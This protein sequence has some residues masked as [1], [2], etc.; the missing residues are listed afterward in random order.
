M[1]SV[2]FS[3]LFKLIQHEVYLQ[4]SSRLFLILFPLSF[5]VGALLLK[6]QP[7][8][9]DLMVDSPYAL[10]KLLILFSITLP[11][12]VTLLSINASTRDHQY[13][14]VEL[15][16]TSSITPSHLVLSRWLGIIIPCM[17]ICIGVLTGISIALFLQDSELTT[18]FLGRTSTLLISFSLFQLPAIL[19]ASSLL[20]GL[21][22]FSRSPLTLYIAGAIAFFSYQMLLIFT[23]SPIM[24]QPVS[25]NETFNQIFLLF[26]PIGSSA[27]FE[28]AQHW[29]PDDRNT[30]TIPLS[31]QLIT[32]RIV[33]MTLAFLCLTAIVQ[34]MTLQLPSKKRTK[35]NHEIEKQSKHAPQYKRI[36]ADETFKAQW[37]SFMSLVKREYLSTIY[38]KSFTL[39]LL[40]W[41]VVLISE[42]MTGFTHL[43]SLDVTPLATTSIALS[44]FQ[45]DVLPRFGMLFLIFFAAQIMWRDKELKVHE[46]I[47]ASP[48][49]NRQL[50][51]SRWLTLVLL[52]LTLITIAIAISSVLQSFFGGTPDL[53]VYLK[54]Y[55]Y[56]GI[57]LAC[58][59]S[60]LLF[61]HAIAPNK[62]TGIVLSI[63]FILLSQTSLGAKIGLE[64]GLFKFANSPPI[65]YS[66]MIQ[67]TATDDAFFG[68]MLF[69]TSLAALF[70]AI[71]YRLYNRGLANS[72]LAQVRV[73]TY[74]WRTPTNIVFCLLILASI[75]TG[76]H[77]FY[78]TNI[79]G[80]YQSRASKSDWKAAYE[81]KYTQYQN[82]PTPSIVKVNTQVDL[83]PHARRLTLNAE[84]QLKNQNADPIN[85][86][87]IS[88]DRNTLYTQM[89]L[90]GGQL[91]S[92]DKEFNQ[93]LFRLDKPLVS[94]ASVTLTFALERQQNGYLGTQYDS[95]I[96]P[97][98]IYFRSIRYLPFIGFVTHYQLKHKQEREAYGLP[99]LPP[100]TPLEQ[101]IDEHQG[102][103]SQDYR[104]AD[105]ET[106][107]STHKTHTAIAAGELVKQWHNEER[108]YFHYKTRQPIHD[109]TAYLSG[110]FEQSSVTHRGISV[111]VYHIAEHKSQAAL[112]QEAMIDTLDYASEQFAPYPV[113]QLRLIEVPYTLGYSAYALPQTILLDE[114]KGFTV[115]RNNTNAFDHQYRRTVHE[116]AHQW[117]GH[118]LDSAV[119]QGGS[120]LVET[121]AKYTE[122]VLL[123]QKYGQEYVRRLMRYEHN[124][125]LNG[126][127]RSL[128]SELPLYRNDETH[129]IY[130][131][132][133]VAM[134]ALKNQ[135]GEKVI[136][137]ALAELIN[138]YAYP[139]PPPTTLDFI[140]LLEQ[141]AL[142]S[143]KSFIES[144]F[145]HVVIND[146]QI[147]SA[148]VVG[149][150]NALY[151]IEVCVMNNG[152]IDEGGNKK[153]FDSELHR[154][155]LVFFSDNPAVLY[156][157]PTDEKT[158]KHTW[159]SANNQLRCLSF[160]LDEKPEF[161]SLDPYYLTLD[162]AR[163][164]NV[165]ALE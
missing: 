12:L 132:G 146:W 138:Q 107:I 85:E 120:V 111:E 52:P 63:P 27:F 35:T 6:G 69:W 13:Q 50:L 133:A 57:P 149:R 155:M 136:N 127:G 20:L 131:K 54:L 95:V 18:S 106:V 115:D 16:Y 91:L 140:R 86:I 80:H 123:E 21:G 74:Q 70:V 32:N 125:Y 33:T 152:Y 68:Y 137:K 75:T 25:I 96:L 93:Y 38:T 122:L 79:E 19:L 42:L 126:R 128:E 64:H 67:F 124:R 116:T 153:P 43:E 110:K 28:Q 130:S 78:R 121:L 113:Q 139:K 158:I 150:T 145:K 129:I 102:D 29:T 61:L 135:L 134:Y 37:M 73:A 48:V 90:E 92:H 105:F 142:P 97:D 49:S 81:K 11:G 72:L 89:Q 23:G 103:F 159:I 22:L 71:A 10:T 162:I 104:W 41:C 87:L 119:Q 26:D 101:A 59:A 65:Q 2:N 55:Y 144:W 66:E 17:I 24:A 143:D 53:L 161:V 164:N 117:W 31:S 118:L 77:V 8:S 88:V 4:C 9:S 56:N 40:F 58:T 156:D 154:G 1:N 99:P 147:D 45:Y 148:K 15:T 62:I 151:K 47:G 76:I 109:V 51:L 108:Q 14:M 82:Q 160:S 94:G 114:L 165:I 30:N 157:Q 36:L 100:V 34:R 163:D 39:I 98:F 84:Y 3:R 5:V 83:Y 7:I 44:R 141:Y 46:L 60:L 112:H